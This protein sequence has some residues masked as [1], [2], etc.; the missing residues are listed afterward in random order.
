MIIIFT[1]ENIEK[2]LDHVWHW[3]LTI[4][5]YGILFFDNI[6][7]IYIYMFDL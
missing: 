4:L 5:F 1:H 7:I 2:A 3:E 6:Y